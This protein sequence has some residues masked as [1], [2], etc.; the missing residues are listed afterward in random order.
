MAVNWIQARE[1]L[2]AALQIPVE[3]RSPYLD[4][5]CPDPELR[6][7]VESL[8]ISYDKATEFLEQPAVTLL[9]ESW[10]E[11]ESP[12]PWI[13]RRIGSYLIE[14]ELGEGG[15]G[16]VFQAV[17][18]DDEYQKRVAIKLVKG[19]FASSFAITRFKAER[20]I[21]A[22]LEHPNIARLLD[23][24]RTEDGYPY[25]VMEFVDGVPIDEYCDAHRLTISQRLQ[26]FRTVCDAVQFAHQNLI[27]H[28]DLKPGNIL[29]TNDGVPK[30]LD[31]G[32]A[33]LL[34]PDPL[35][36][37]PEQTLGFVRM[38]TPDYASPEQVC[39]E[40]INTTTDVYSLG[41]VLYILLSGHHPYQLTGT[42]PQSLEDIICHTEPLSRAKS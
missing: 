15:M 29:V 8:I 9:A 13:G 39:G 25:L 28:R 30:L 35:S 33:K 22:G 21:L 34:S 16:T 12:Q 24:G 10:R 27:I 32:I 38:L 31:F 4:N 3:D 26:L 6:R 20:Q 19:G 7:Y 17:R 11:A 18:A 23:G 40:A 14:K 5:A 42:S 2:D 37:T 1:I 41:V 36:P